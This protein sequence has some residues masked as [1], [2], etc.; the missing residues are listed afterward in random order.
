MKRKLTFLFF[1][2]FSSLWLN[3]MWA[4]GT[5]SG[6][7]ADGTGE[8]L[9]GAT[10]LLEGTTLGTSADLDG[11]YTLKNVKAGTYVMVVSYLGYATQRVTLA[12]TDGANLT[13]NFTLVEDGMNLDEL[14]VVG[15]GTKQKRNLTASITQ[16]NEADL[17]NGT[18]TN[19]L[20]TIQG[21]APGVLIT[22]D[23]AQAGSPITVRV[24]GTASIN[25]SE[26]LYVID[27]IPVENRDLSNGGFGYNLNTLSTLNPADIENITIL[28]D[29]T[30]TAIYGSRGA[31]GVVLITT[32]R[33]KKGKPRFDVEIKQ[34][35]S[36]I[37]KRLDLL[38]AAEYIA[39]SKEAYNNDVARG[40]TN[41]DT[42]PF[43]L[44][45]G[46]TEA[47][48]LANNTDW[49]DKALQTG[50][51]TDVN[52]TFTGGTKMLTYN[53]GAS[54][55][56]EKTILVGND[57]Q[58]ANVRLNLDYTPL[59]WVKMG[60]NISYAYTNTALPPASYAGGF[61]TAQSSALPI[62]PVYDSTGAY[63]YPDVNVNPVA[64]LENRDQDHIVNRIL[65]GVFA[66]INFT[67]NLT[68]RADFSIDQS[69]QEEN[70]FENH[71]IRGLPDDR[72]WYRTIEYRSWNTNQTLRYNKVFNEVH[73]VNLL[74]GFSAQRA[75][76]EYTFT[77]WEGNIIES[78]NIDTLQDRDG[79]GRNYAFASF[80]GRA[81]YTYNQRYLLDF[82]MRRDGSSRF[83]PENRWGT[84][85]AVSAAWIVSEENFLR[86]H[87]HL[88]YLKLKGGWGQAGY[89]EIGD[90]EYA[91][92]FS[93][94]DN[95]LYD[96]QNG[97]APSS[98]A[99]PDLS[100]EVQTTTNGGLE[101]GF[102][103]G[104][105]SG[106]IG[107]FYTKTTE[108]LINTVLAGTTGFTGVRTNN[109]SLENKGWDLGINSRNIVKPKF[110]W[111]TDFSF[112]HSRNK[113]LDLQ[114]Q[115]VSGTN[116]GDNRAIEGQPIGAWLLVRFYG[117]DPATG[118]E[119]WLDADG[120]II[121]A[122]AGASTTERVVIGNPYPLYWGGLTNN[123]EYKNFD[124]SFQF[125]YALDFNIYDDHGKRQLANMAFNWN[126]DAR[127][128]DRWQQAGDITDIRRLSL[129]QNWDINSSRHLYDGDYIRLKNLTVGYNVPSATTKKLK[130]QAMRVY[131]NATNLLTWTK[132]PG[133]DPE[134][135]RDT[136]GS[137]TQ[138]VSYL[139]NPQARVV[140]VGVRVGF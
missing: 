116:F 16:I 10:V 85:P 21:K 46:I 17:R 11:T 42:E 79:V 1:I 78:T 136:S 61:G 109:A 133:W 44:P 115:E 110:K 36:E 41:P 125:N 48:G 106:E 19:P 73:D 88:T 49:L 31:G 140:S 67:K 74:G 131:M 117:V 22:T 3:T 138:S 60:T 25:G 29:A 101:F 122:S 118:D 91:A 139:S 18:A 135:N 39:L 72:A 137:I 68:G 95:I 38:N 87:P 81:N 112:S 111:S 71:I 77:E 58:R 128:L 96:G 54:Y 43:A 93:V 57:F 23:G 90:F 89:A 105:L 53:A 126:Q 98:L 59:D 50:T 76:E 80:F 127:T 4:Q 108:M 33:G 26:P 124:F 34:G 13:Q 69:N 9:I 52:A 97:S 35:I 15:Y 51:F 99:V 8:T 107:A 132:Y 86:D 6:E 62:Y 5:I 24:R 82:T 2:A 94:P 134:V 92:Y 123:F 28:K 32:K 66:E 100:W 130:I 120:N 63:F 113:V 119:L 12:V 27:G 40:L 7:I 65:G 45:R 84:F 20:S 102:W 37:T 129:K 83:G 47:Q 70:Y 75:R 14:V 55:R 30:A 104:R 56:K 121:V 114:G 64:Q 103:D